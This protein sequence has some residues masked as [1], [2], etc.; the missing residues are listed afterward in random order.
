MSEGELYVG[1]N[2]CNR[3]AENKE[4]GLLTPKK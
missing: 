2:E 4:E 3:I 1:W